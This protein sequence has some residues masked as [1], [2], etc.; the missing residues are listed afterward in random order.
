MT[1]N[2]R[3]L[4]ELTRQIREFRPDVVVD[5]VFQSCHACN[6]ESIKVERHVR[7]KEGLPFLKIVTDFSSEDVGQ[8][9]TRIG[10]VLEMAR[11]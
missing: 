4:D 7:E 9:R 8:L 3:R 1:P 6:I 2:G 5:L 10:A 11:R